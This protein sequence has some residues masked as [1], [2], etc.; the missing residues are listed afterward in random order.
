MERTP[1]SYFSTA[2]MNIKL[3]NEHKNT[4]KVRKTNKLKQMYD[5]THSDYEMAVNNY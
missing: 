4:I 1:H 3:Q 2:T 5:R